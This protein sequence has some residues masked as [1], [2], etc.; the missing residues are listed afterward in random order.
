VSR[1]FSFWEKDI[2]GQDSPKYGRWVDRCEQLDARLAAALGDSTYNSGEISNFRCRGIYVPA[3]EFSW[4][5]VK[6][7]H[8]LLTGEF[9][10]WEVFIHVGLGLK[11]DDPC[12]GSV[13]VQRD[14]AFA[15]QGLEAFLVCGC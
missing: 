9:A 1:D 4:E 14:M 7:V 12:L 3:A 2:G 8:A 11:A 10:N 13:L 5:T 6:A 15:I